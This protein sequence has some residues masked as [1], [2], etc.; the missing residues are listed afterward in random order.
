MCSN[1]DLKELGLA[2]GPRKKLSSFITQQNE[3]LKL[4]KE[5]KAKEAAK[6]LEQEQKELKARRASVETKVL[7]VKIIQGLAGTGQTYVEYPQLMFQP[8]Q[9]FLLGSPLGLFLTVRYDVKMLCS[10]E[11]LFICLFLLLKELSIE[12]PT[13]KNSLYPM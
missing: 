8:Q 1:D 11:K 4:R 2:M 9:L 7:K 6:K 10:V 5:R 12:I 3:D 13:V